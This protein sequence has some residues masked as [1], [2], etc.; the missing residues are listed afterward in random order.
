M[1]KDV[2]AK[3]RKGRARIR[4]MLRPI[5]TQKRLDRFVKKM[6]QRKGYAAELAERNE[7]LKSIIKET[8]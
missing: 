4:F 3:Q 5:R 6:K 1:N 7:Y 8:K 2:I